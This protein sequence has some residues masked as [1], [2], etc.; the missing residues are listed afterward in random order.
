MPTSRRAAIVGLLLIAM[1]GCGSDSSDDS[2]SPPTSA[3]TLVGPHWLLQDGAGVS[4]GGVS[5]TAEFADGR[6][7]G[8]SGCN[9]YNAAYVVDGDNLT[10]GP[11]ITSTRLACEPGPAAVEAAYLERLPKV[12]R[13]EIDGTTLKLLDAG[14]ET[15][16]EYEAVKGDTAI[17]GT[18]TATS[19]YAGNSVQ[20]VA[21]GSTLTADFGAEE[22]SG[23]GGCN[24]FSGPYEA[25]QRSI[26]LGPLASTLKA[27]ADPALQTQEQQYL[28]ALDLAATFRV[29]GDQLELFRDDGGIAATFVR[30][31]ATG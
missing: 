27:C 5:V 22:V 28:N 14:G 24:R 18:W 10:I 17:L 19:F 2:K 16:L 8:S 13:Y 3:T 12:S 1:A 6:V 11:D 23:D 29:T 31:A 20:S 4:T 15:V 25:G 26:K 9:T 30:P 7:G 21:V